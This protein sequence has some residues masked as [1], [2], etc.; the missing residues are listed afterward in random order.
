MELP[1]A[2]QVRIQQVKEKFG[3]MRF[4]VSAEGDETFANDI[5]QIAGWAETATEG[6]CCVTGKPGVQ[7]GP[8]WVLT[9]SSDM[10]ALRGEDMNRFREALYPQEPPAVDEPD[11]T[12]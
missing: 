9:L 1:D 2:G 12:P 5:Y 6:R 4:Y 10:E 7:S 11:L 3:T 8:G